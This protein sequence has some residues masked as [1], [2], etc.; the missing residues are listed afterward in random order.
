MTAALAVTLLGQDVARERK[1]QQ[2][3]DLLETKGDFA[4]AMPLLEDVARSTDRPLAA[5]A[6]LYLGQA[7]ERRGTDAARKTYERIVRDFSN[8]QQIAAQA[9]ARLAALGAPSQMTAAALLPAVRTVW[10]GSDVPAEADVSPDG[11]FLVHVDEKTWGVAVR[12]VAAGTTRQLTTGAAPGQG[13][14]EEAAFSPDG[15]QVAYS[16][17]TE[18]DGK[19]YS[20]VR[21]I[22]F[23]TAGMPAPRIVYEQE[24]YLT[25][26]NWSAD[27]KRIAVDLQR[28]DGSNDL[29]FISVDDGKPH[30]LKTVGWRSASKLALSPDG[31]LLAYDLPAND[32]TAQQDIFVI[33]TEGRRETAVVASVARERLVGWT[34]DGRHL[35][36]LREGHGGV[37]LW[38]QPMREG[39]ADG[40]PM[41][42]ASN[43]RGIPAGISASGSIY[44]AD[45]ERDVDLYAATVDL[46]TGKLAGS[47]PSKV[48][49]MWAR[50]GKP[51]WSRDG[52]WLAY[53]SSGHASSPRELFLSI[54][55]VETGVARTFPLKL[56]N[57]AVYD[58]SADS[59][60]IVARGTDF[61]GREGMFLIDPQNGEVVPLLLNSSTRRHFS[62]H[63]GTDAR[64][65]LYTRGTQGLGGFLTAR[66][67]DTGEERELFRVG[68]AGPDARIP[69][70]R[71]MVTSP[72][73]RLVAG[74]S[75]DP[76]SVL[77][78]VTSDGA[79]HREVYRRKRPF[80]F[81]F[82]ALAWTPDSRALLM[83]VSGDTDDA[84]RELWVVP[85]EE[86]RRPV[87][88]DLGLKNILNDGIAIH[89]DGRQIA[90]SVAKP[91]KREIR[92]V[93]N[94]LGALRK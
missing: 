9:R 7:Q 12:D 44:L 86:G 90:F 81:S 33:T 25:L 87:R 6:L 39:R 62:P 46:T 94:V 49:T 91:L 75:P 64:T 29:A 5:R 82:D 71:D 51:R 59:R 27:G 47:A 17:S 54:Q 32:N 42:L 68:P 15:R 52:K 14:A 34:R 72:D 79:T 4:R 66:N 36:F 8:E 60:T 61:Q 56:A 70:M 57:F 77:H 26:Y 1:L 41:Q 22:R 38:A 24:T 65:V 85:V 3:I 23:Q 16:W 63:W 67:I 89:P 76:E 88:L 80:A 78:V 31:T 37:N 55:S 53:Q 58:W 2:A 40:E 43:V 93:E 84:P 45:F 21:I 74:Y 13:G 10:S 48:P 83:N 30:V 19:E 69:G 92:V 11:R 73:G 35:L 50:N 28:A 20:Q 18:Q